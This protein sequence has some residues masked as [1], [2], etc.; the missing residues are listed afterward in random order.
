MDYDPQEPNNCAA[1]GNRCKEYNQRKNSG[2]CRK[3]EN[4]RDLYHFHPAGSFSFHGILL[5]TAINT[6]EGALPWL[7]AG[8]ENWTRMNRYAFTWSKVYLADSTHEKTQCCCLSSP[9]VTSK[10]DYTIANFE[11]GW[12]MPT[13]KFHMMNMCMSLDKQIVPRSWPTWFRDGC[14]KMWCITNAC[15]VSSTQVKSDQWKPKYRV[16]P[17]K[18]TMHQT[19]FST[20]EKMIFNV[21]YYADRQFCS[22]S[23]KFGHY[24]NFRFW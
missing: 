9:C 6:K 24:Y 21:I 2:Q 4:V 7:W 5:V 13:Y 20:R 1:R 14:L 23:T 19:W 10:P 8:W 11:K 16:Q 18:S 22:Y 12:L 17:L 3:L 15:V